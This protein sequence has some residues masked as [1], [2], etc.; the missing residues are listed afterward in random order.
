[1][2]IEQ[3]DNYTITTALH[4]LVLFRVFMDSLREALR[5]GRVGDF[6]TPLY[7]PRVEDALE[8]INHA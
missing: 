2:L 3:G 6:L 4:N 5:L 8:A 7:G 1:M